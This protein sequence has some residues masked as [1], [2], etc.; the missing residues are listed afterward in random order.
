MKS[1]VDQILE[2]WSLVA[3]LARCGYFVPA[4]GK[5][6]SPFRADN[7]PSC[8]IYGETIRDRSK[9]ESFDSIRVFAEHNGFSN[10]EAIRELYR[11]IKDGKVPQQAPQRKQL[12]SKHKLVIPALHYSIAE[13][14]QVAKLRG[15]TNQGVDFAGFMGTLGFADVAGFPCWILFDGDRKLAEARRMDGKKFPAI[16]SLAERKAHT[17]RGSCKSWPLGMNPPC[18][19]V[20][21]G[22]PVWLVEGGPDYLAACDVLVHS[23]REFLPVAMLGAGQ[24]IHAEALPFFKGRDVRI[25]GHPG[26]AGLNAIQFWEK[27]LSGAGASVTALQLGGYDLNELVTIHGAVAVATDLHDEICH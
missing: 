26:E 13:A 2:R 24:H 17:L 3:M 27:Q 5:F 16:G 23:S 4:V 6:C 20:P 25:M 8:E 11:E 12:P 18:V 22:L 15:L 10:A 14:E 9:G 21:S 19:K 1:I 7:N